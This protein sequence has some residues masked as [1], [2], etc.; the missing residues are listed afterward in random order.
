M[1][2]TEPLPRSYLDARRL[3]DPSIRMR[4]VTRGDAAVLPE[5]PHD[6]APVRGAAGPR[7]P[8]SLARHWSFLARSRRSNAF[9]AD[10]DVLRRGTTHV[11]GILREVAVGT[12]EGTITGVVAAVEFAWHRRARRTVADANTRLLQT[13]VPPVGS[14]VHLWLGTDGAVVVM[15]LAAG[16]PAGSEP[17]AAPVGIGDQLAVLARLRADGSLSE[18]EFAAAKRQLLE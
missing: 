7:S 13:E 2:T 3:A 1:T 6:L 5:D 8:R 11:E 15:Q 16:A 10:Y 17:V 9:A 18:A 14:R 4:V 12:S